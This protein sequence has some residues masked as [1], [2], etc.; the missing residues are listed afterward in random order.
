VQQG[1]QNQINIL[2]L[3]NMDKSQRVW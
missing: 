1:I 3:G 2:K